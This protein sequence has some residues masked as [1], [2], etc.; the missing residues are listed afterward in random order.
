MSTGC[1]QLFLWISFIKAELLRYFKTAVG[2]HS[3]SVSVFKEPVIR[4][5]HTGTLPVYQY[6]L[7]DNA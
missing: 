6:S 1:H 5:W 2:L 7:V 3:F 4:E